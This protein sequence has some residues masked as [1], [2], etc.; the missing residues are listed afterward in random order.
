MTNHVHLLMTPREADAISRVMQSLGRRYV[1]YINREYARSGTLWEGRYKACLV[2][3]ENY[4]LT[5]MRYIELNPVRAGMVEQ[6]TQYPWSSH[7]ANAQAEDNGLITLHERYARLG[8]TAESRCQQY[9]R[10]FY[11]QIDSDEIHAIRNAL[12]YSIPLGDEEFVRQIEAT[13]GK[14]FGYAK[15]GRPK[16][17]EDEAT[18]CVWE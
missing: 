6:P 7:R 9:R 5:C 2:D 11:D 3:A 18:Y 17:R 1:Q 10:L 4:L 8:S 12:A 14:K 16:V 13:L 15:R